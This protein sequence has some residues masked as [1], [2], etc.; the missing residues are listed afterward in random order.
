MQA[1]LHALIE[2]ECVR[3]LDPFDQQLHTDFSELYA[4]TKR[5]TTE[6]NLILPE[7]GHIDLEPILR[8]Y[9]LLEVPIS[10]MCRQDCKG[11]C[12]VC[13]EN[14]NRANCD[15]NTQPDDPRLS[16]LKDFIDQK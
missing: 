2:I 7:D 8:E 16:V 9:M 15:H 5:S 1:K 6:S 13:G 10:S 3:C 4:F 11:L 14:R 12:L